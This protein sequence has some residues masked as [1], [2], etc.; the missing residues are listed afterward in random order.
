MALSFHLYTKNNNIVFFWQ[1][2][3]YC[4]KKPY[5]QLFKCQNIIFFNKN[6][7]FKILICA[8]KAYINNTSFLRQKKKTSFLIQ[9]SKFYYFIK[10]RKCMLFDYLFKIYLINYFSYF[11]VLSFFSYFTNIVISYIFYQVV[12]KLVFYFLKWISE[13]I[14]Y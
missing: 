5:I 7:L 1:K 13:S 8:L 3:K 2:K 11:T 14:E 6:L 4:F 10:A 12:Y 9:R